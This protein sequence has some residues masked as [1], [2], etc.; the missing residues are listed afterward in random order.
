MKSI[1][2]SHSEPPRCFLCGTVRHLEKHHIFGGALRKKSE[3]F[4][5]TVHLCHVCHNEPPYGVHHNRDTSDGLKRTAQAAAMARFGWST[6]DFI[7]KFGK[8]YLF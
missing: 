2:E 3:Q 5:L 4:G 8:N 7:R 6:N 1:L